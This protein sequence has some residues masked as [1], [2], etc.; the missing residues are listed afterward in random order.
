MSLKFKTAAFL[1][2]KRLC[3]FSCHTSQEAE[4]SLGMGV[5]ITL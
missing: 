3:T 2:I 4:N 5:K 1:Q